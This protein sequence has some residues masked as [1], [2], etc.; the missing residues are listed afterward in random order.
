M[1]E[2]TEIAALIPAYALHLLDQEE[3]ARIARHLEVCPT[4][5]SDLAAYE[6]TA[7]GLA[8][9]I[10]Q[11]AP[12]TYLK[13]R[14]MARVGAEGRPAAAQTAPPEGPRLSWWGAVQAALQARVPLWMPVGVA[15]VAALLVSG[16]I[17]W[18]RVAHPRQQEMMTIMLSGTEDAPE[19]LGVMVLTPDQPEGVLVVS[20]LAPLP[21]DQQY[22][23]W[24]IET[25]GSRDSGAVFS[26]DAAGRAQVI[27]TGRRPLAEYASFGITIEPAG[28]SPGPTGPK[29]LGGDL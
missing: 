23:L 24:L 11:Q 22:Q 2:H 27:V 6:E 16:V 19:A 26:P 14:L 18:Q 8:A 21:A 12:P 4:C 20:S 13:A 29:V 10:P 28:G 9:A 7:A 17:L 3:A 5:R 1:T 25:D 15:L